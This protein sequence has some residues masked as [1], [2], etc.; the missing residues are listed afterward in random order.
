MKGAPPSVCGGNAGAADG[1]GSVSN[2]S[3]RASRPV[4]PGYSGKVFT[5]LNRILG[6]DAIG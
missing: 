5:A 2:A 3:L 6:N 4:R 1:I